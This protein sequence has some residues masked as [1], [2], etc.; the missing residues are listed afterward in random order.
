MYTAVNLEQT[1]R[2]LK[3]SYVVLLPKC[4]RVICSLNKLIPKLFELK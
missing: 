1:I 2:N 3:L 4:N